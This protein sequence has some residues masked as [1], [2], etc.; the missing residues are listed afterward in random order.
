MGSG[1]QNRRQGSAPLRYYLRYSTLYF[2]KSGFV[3]N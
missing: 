1:W 2:T 3:K